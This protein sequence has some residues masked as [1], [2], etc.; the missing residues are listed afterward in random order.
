MKATIHFLEI[1]DNGRKQLYLKI[2][3]LKK[4]QK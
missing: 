2:S 4:A 1:I 3:K